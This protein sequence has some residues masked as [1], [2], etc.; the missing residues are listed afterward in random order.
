VGPYVCGVLFSRTNCLNH[1]VAAATTS[2]SRVCHAM[3]V[4]GDRCPPAWSLQRLQRRP[5]SHP[6][7]WRHSATHE[8]FSVQR[9][10]LEKANK[11]AHFEERDDYVG[12]PV[13]RTAASQRTTRGCCHGQWT[14]AD[15]HRCSDDKKFDPR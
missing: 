2:E 7:T 11:L 1:H 14:T 5:T 4:P 13:R 10:A 15:H 12:H 8:Y 3:Q 9:A 6:S